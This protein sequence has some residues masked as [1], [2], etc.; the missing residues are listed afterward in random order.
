MPNRRRFLQ[1]IPAIPALGGL[2]GAS[3]KTIAKRDY[4]KELGI[5]PFINAAGSYTTLTASLMP[6]EVMA[7]MQYASKQFVPLIELQDAVGKRIAELVG[8][9]AAMVTSG[10]A[11]ALMCGTS[12][13]V[14]GKDQEKIRRLPDTTGMKNEVIIQKSHRYGYD[15]AVR[16]NGI[17]MVEVETSEDLDRAVNERTAM[18]LFFNDADPRGQI[19]IQEFINLGKK[20]NVPT[21]NDAAADVPPVEN[22]SKYI[23]MGFDL[24]TFSGGKNICGPQSAGLLFGR[25]DLIEAA[26][27]NTSPYSDSIG[28]GCKVNKEEILGMLVALELYF[29][30]DHDADRREGDRR[31]KYIAD[32][33]RAIPTV[34]SDVQ[35][36]PIANHVPHLHVNW[37]Q[38]KITVLDV[39]K[40]LREGDPSIE[41]VPGSREELIINPWM[42]Q[43]GE[44]EVVARRLREILKAA[45]A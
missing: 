5:R 43:P 26:R 2:S 41:V 29:K 21:F 16:S 11:G 12:A 39:V 22:L 34:R 40:K 20:H 1:T 19:K 25:K 7:A 33:I 10:A 31:V 9:E 42:T 18:M 3:A 32:T 23:K 27:L 13:C 6:P 35:V 38:S 44:A 30:R 28:R 8:A 37:D 4:F 15:H 14:A 45:L 17:K 36:P 24:V